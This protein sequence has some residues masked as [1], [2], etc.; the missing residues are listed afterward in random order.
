MWAT[1]FDNGAVIV[2]V[3]SS[4]HFNFMRTK[5]HARSQNKLTIKYIH[6]NSGE[7]GNACGVCLYL[8]CV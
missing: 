3:S 6:L 1:A 2:V 8:L 5:N 7:P 4:H